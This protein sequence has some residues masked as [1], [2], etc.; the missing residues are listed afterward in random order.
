MRGQPDPRPARRTRR[1]HPASHRPARSG[2]R[3]L[4]AS[5]CSP[6][7]G[8]LD[9]SRPGDG[10][11]AICPAAPPATPAGG[12]DART[13]R[14]ERRRGSDRAERLWPGGRR[15]GH[16]RVLPCV[17]EGTPA[18]AAGGPSFPLRMPRGRPNGDRASRRPVGGARYVHIHIPGCLHD[19][20][21]HMSRSPARGRSDADPRPRRPSAPHGRPSAG[22]CPAAAPASGLGR[23]APAAPRRTDARTGRHAYRPSPCAAHE[24]RRDETCRYVYASPQH[25]SSP[26]DRG[27]PAAGVIA[28]RADGSPSGPSTARPGGSSAPTRGSLPSSTPRTA[29]AAVA[30]GRPGERTV[31]VASRPAR[32]PGFPPPPPGTGRIAAQ[33]CGRAHPGHGSA[34]RSLSRRRPELGRGPPAAAPR[35]LQLVRSGASGRWPPSSPHAC[36][37]LLPTGLRRPETIRP[38]G[39][40]RVTSG[41]DTSACPA[42]ILSRGTPR[43]IWICRYLHVSIP[44]ACSLSG[45]RTGAAASLGSSGPAWRSRPASTPRGMCSLRL[46]AHG[47]PPTRSNVGGRRVD[48]TLPLHRRHGPA[49]S[50]HRPA[51]RGGFAAASGAPRIGL[52]DGADAPSGRSAPPPRMNA[53]EDPAADPATGRGPRPRGPAYPRRP[54]GNGMGRWS[55]DMET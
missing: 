55:V 27:G 17:G 7:A 29:R 40:S 3:W 23:I 14:V 10:S 36:S 32:S 39:R 31:V 12:A 34:V 51:A 16:G 11:D 26:L 6:A 15:G 33:G 44:P 5:G 45:G 22:P 2:V 28:P 20:P 38:G 42:R 50:R 48:G 4:A 19:R 18:R 8:W 24:P 25:R 41:M 9:R 46:E 37:S 54:E 13:T 35:A 1:P 30:E 47:T 52:A 21:V 43:G 49:A 53:P